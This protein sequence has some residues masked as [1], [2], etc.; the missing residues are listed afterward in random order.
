VDKLI[1]TQGESNAALRAEVDRAVART[2]S[3][4]AEARR[5]FER[6]QADLTKKSE[7]LAVR[8]RSDV[9]ASNTA[10]A[11]ETRA[12]HQRLAKVQEEQE[13]LIR[14]LRRRSRNGRFVLWLLILTG[15]AVL[16]AFVYQRWAELLSWWT[17]FVNR[18]W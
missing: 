12:E 18:A 15:G 2:D 4:M 9:A 6:L 17:G 8:V 7:E 1:A 11:E 16:G 3:S 5:E 14:I 13:R 10:L